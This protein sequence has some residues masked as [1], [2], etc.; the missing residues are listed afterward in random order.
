MVGEPKASRKQT[1]LV[2]A[3]LLAIMGVVILPLILIELKAGWLAGL[4]TA[5]VAHPF[6]NQRIAGVKTPP[7]ELR[8][9]RMM[10]Y[11]FAA[12]F[13]IFNVGWVLV[14]GSL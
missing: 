10:A 1:W 3:A 9:S 11:A 12:A 4:A 14:N 5:K 2:V 6:L 7:H 8:D 13:I